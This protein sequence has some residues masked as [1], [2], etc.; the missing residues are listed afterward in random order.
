MTDNLINFNDNYDNYNYILNDTSTNVNYF[1]INNNDNILN[2]DSSN[3]NYFDHS[4]FNIK[5]NNNNE[6]NNII[7]FDNIINS[8]I[9]VNSNNNDK[10]LYDDYKDILKNFSYNYITKE[11][12]NYE[13]INLTNINTI[14]KNP[15]KSIN[16]YLV[17]KKFKL[18]DDNIPNF[19]YEFNN[20]KDEKCNY[21]LY[22]L[23]SNQQLLI[24]NDNDNDKIN[25][26]LIGSCRYSNKEC[27]DFI[28]KKKCDKY[29]MIW[30]PKTCNNNL[31][32]IPFELCEDKYLYNSVNNNCV[33][34]PDTYTYVD[35]NCIKNSYII[36]NYRLLTPSNI[37]ISK[38]D[39]NNVDER[40]NLCNQENNNNCEI[41]NSNKVSVKCN[42][43]DERI[44]DYI[45]K[46]KSKYYLINNYNLFTPSNNLL[47]PSNQLLTPSNQL[48]TPSNNLLTPSN[49]LLTPSN[50]L[51][52]PSDNILT[53]SN[54]L[55]TPSNNIL[56]PSDNILT[57]SNNLLT[58][59]NNLLTPSNNLLTPS[60]NILTPS[61]NLLTP[62]NQLCNNNNCEIIN[63]KKCND[64]DEIINDH[65]CKSKSK[66]YLVDNYSLLI[67]H[68]IN[69]SLN[70]CNDG[71]KK[72]GDY[73]CKPNDIKP[74]I[75][76]VLNTCPENYIKY[77]LGC[78]NI[79]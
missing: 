42:N 17:T 44:N 20:F 47:T 52:T 46:T 62:S 14:L 1:D 36:N 59:S 7:T 73:L 6:N 66:L 64:D 45:C 37:E 74:Q 21:D 39:I 54:N 51:L 28:D 56:T 41:I 63:S 43:G 78:I 35:N 26:N 3:F 38:N 10:L 50:N 9:V 55:L 76:N 23:N 48:L 60:D 29:D 40:L 22:N 2:I 72:I 13:I 8:N 31:K 58:P 53:P 4:A 67:P 61:N 15:K 34:C 25:I 27:V 33:K 18:D 19:K 30:S 69:Y 12:N 57:P 24:D 5:Y 11:S 75:K 68:N 65:L 79:N 49:Q 70:K 71:D 32:I 16:C 77:K